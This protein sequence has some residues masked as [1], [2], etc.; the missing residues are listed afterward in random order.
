MAPRLG[1]VEHPDTGREMWDYL[2]WPLAP[3][4]VHW[5]GRF[6]WFLGWGVEK[7]GGG[8][9]GGGNE[10]IKELKSKEN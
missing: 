1:G 3:R 6:C 8:G 2:P 7:R 9:G 4:A 5:S 10:V